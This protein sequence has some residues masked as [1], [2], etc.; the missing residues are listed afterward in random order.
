M[1]TTPEEFFIKGLM[2]QP[3]PS[4]PVFFDL[5][6]KPNCSSEGQRHV[7]ND[8]MLPYISRVLLED[9]EDDK[10][11]NH[12][13][14]LQVQQPFAQIL[15]SPSFGAKVSNM[16]GASNWLEDG[17][18]HDSTLDLVSSNDSDVVQA[19][20]KGME[21]ANMLLPTGNKFRGRGQMNQMVQERSNQIG[22]RKRYNRDARLED[23]VIRTRRAVMTIKEQEKSCANEIL[24]EMMLHAYETCIRGMDKLRI[25]M[26]SELG[27]ENR[28]N[29]NKMAK[30][31]VVDI[32]R[33]LISC[34]QALASNNHTD[35]CDLLKQIKQHASAT[36]DATQRLA[37]CFTK[38]LEARLVG[39]GSKL[40]QLLMAEPPSVVEF[41]KAYR[42]YFAAC[43]FNK[44]ALNFSTMTIMQAMAG[45]SRLHIVDYG[46]HFGFQWVGLLHLL[47]SREGGPP[48]VKITAIGPPKP[49]SCP[50]EWIE[51][52]ECRLRKFA[53]EFGLPSLKFHRIM[54]KWED[55][56]INDLNTEADEVLVVNDLFNFSTLMDD[57]GFFVDPCPRDTVLN[58]IKKMRPDVFIQSI[59]NRS[60]GSS[61]LPRFRELLF[62][63]MALFDILDATIPRESKSR[64]ALEQVM[65]GRSAVNAIA[66]EG[67]DLVDRPEKYKQW[68]ARNQRIGLRQLPLKSSIIEVVKDKVK[69]DHHKDFFIS[70]DGQWLLQGW[71]GRVLFAHSTWVAE[72]ACSR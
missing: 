22:V 56:C 53:R 65:L 21:E 59:L 41:L 37:Q 69:N 7:H 72:D 55:V 18:R 14:L 68:Q 25:S 46:M 66:C 30:H 19:F 49:K 52:I 58:N 50:A 48:D 8:M 40:W 62:Y 12:P 5:P 32:R 64:L 11:N 71:M 38:G 47:A 33:L 3:P 16:E 43:C 10:L 61:F 15:S 51:G 9:E 23:E 60:Y 4:P 28:K 6:R 26:E 54:K 13:A 63:Y 36:G 31:I 45:K 20:L 42:L 44:V 29:R 1:A 57:T 35:A 17:G 2:E 70:E 39:T 67:L 24:D 27:K 34:A